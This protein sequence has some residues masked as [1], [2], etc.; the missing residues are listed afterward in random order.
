MRHIWFGR[1]LIHFN[2]LKKKVCVGK[3][4]ANTSRK[5]IGEMS[6]R[7]SPW[8]GNLYVKCHLQMWLNI[9]LEQDLYIGSKIQR[10]VRYEL[11]F[12][13]WTNISWRKTIL[14]S[15]KE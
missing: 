2:E 7:E 4:V 6:N 9:I 3:W 15:N 5:K 11:I 10:F 12:I 8:L 14:S 1:I 13:K